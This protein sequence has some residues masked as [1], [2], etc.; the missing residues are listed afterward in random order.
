MPGNSVGRAVVGAK[1]DSVSKK[2]KS[3]ATDSE[4]EDSDSLLER[5]EKKQ[6][7]K[8]LQK[9][10]QAD[11]D[12]EKAINRQIAAQK[13]KNDKQMQEL[14]KGDEAVMGEDEMK[15][16][17]TEAYN[18]IMEDSRLVRLPGHVEQATDRGLWKLK[19]EYKIDGG[20]TVV[21]WCQCPMAYRF[22]CKVQIKLFDGPTYMSLDV[23]G[24]H[25]ADSHSRDKEKSKHLSVKQIEAIHTGVRISRAQSARTLRRNLANFHAD[26]QID[27][28]KLRNVRRQVAKF[29]AD[30]TLEQLDNY[31]IDD[32]YGSLERFAEAKWFETLIEEH[33][34]DDS[35][36]H[37]F[38]FNL[39]EP[40]V[41][42]KS[43]KAKDDIVYLNFT[44]I[45]HLC[46]F[47]RKSVLDS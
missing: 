19:S 33:N 44:S 46:N 43:L 11:R 36:F 28:L 3:Q 37:K 32:S 15:L 45:W 25:N 41:I 10:L 12:S 8:A 29:R 30:L 17:M 7:E 42:G 34:K 35:H 4:S 24:E 2:R 13:S 26:Q 23:R 18:K 6:R 14:A 22:G 47:L 20:R 1:R 9:D 31:K 27:P 38:H 5:L 39:F 21:T 16:R 40:F